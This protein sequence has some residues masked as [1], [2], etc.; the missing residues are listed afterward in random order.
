MTQLFSELHGESERSLWLISCSFDP[1]GSREAYSCFITSLISYQTHSG[2]KSAISSVTITG[3]AVTYEDVV[4]AEHS[5]Q[6]R[7]DWLVFDCGGQRAS[8]S[9][10]GLG[11]Q[12]EP[13][14]VIFP[15]QG[16]TAAWGNEEETRTDGRGRSYVTCCCAERTNKS[17]PAKSALMI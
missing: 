5:S 10:C 12:Q 11:K 13:R 14:E 3:K 1:S 6:V 2:N 17:K 8:G 7:S 16:E 4:T 15:A 9:R